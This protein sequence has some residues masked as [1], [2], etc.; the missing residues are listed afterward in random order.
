M[1]LE[2]SPARQS[3]AVARHDIIDPTYTLNQFCAAEQISRAQLYEA[4]KEGWGP[5]YYWNGKH[6]R[7]THRARLEWQRKREAAARSAA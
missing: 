6:R 4:W 3:A 7:I 2:H 1:S 5:D